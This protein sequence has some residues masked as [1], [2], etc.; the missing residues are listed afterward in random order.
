MQPSPKITP[1]NKSA[2][3]HNPPI[4]N[5]FGVIPYNL[6]DSSDA[7]YILLN[8]V[9]IE[10]TTARKA[11]VA[12]TEKNVITI[13]RKAKVKRKS[14]RNFVKYILSIPT[15]TVITNRFTDPFLLLFPPPDPT[16]QTTF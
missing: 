7:I 4:S 10:N 5:I 13:N 15:T 9:R 2:F 3:K 12:T 8:T 6:K 14:I 11:N 1:E 16:I